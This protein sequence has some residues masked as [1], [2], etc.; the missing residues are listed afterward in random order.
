MFEIKPEL[1]QFAWLGMVRSRYPLT[2]R[3]TLTVEQRIS[4]HPGYQTD[5]EKWNSAYAQAL[6]REQGRTESS[7]GT[8][9][10]YSTD[11]HM[12]DQPL[13]PHAALILT[14]WM[15]QNAARAPDIIAQRC[16]GSA[17][18]CHRARAAG[19]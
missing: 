11:Y 3:S 4:R 8:L 1:V 5:R 9:R 7:S 6:Q 19:S 2:H 12:R 17:L 10:P 16:R 15:L 14:A 18:H 13:K